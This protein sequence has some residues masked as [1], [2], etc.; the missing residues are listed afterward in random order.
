MV[1]DS[2]VGRDMCSK[3]YPTMSHLRRERIV[4]DLV[5]STLNWVRSSVQFH[6]KKTNVTDSVNNYVRK[7]LG[8]RQKGTPKYKTHIIFYYIRTPM[9]VHTRQCT[10]RVRGGCW[11]WWQMSVTR[12]WTWT[13]RIWRGSRSGTWTRVNLLLFIQP[14]FT[15]FGP[16]RSWE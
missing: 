4:G 15:G 10:V 6:K 3:F 8:Q 9:K 7:K 11:C 1:E 12:D 2:W 13:V 14:P 5:P 16:H